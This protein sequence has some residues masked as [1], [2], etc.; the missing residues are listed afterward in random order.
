VVF[1]ILKQI[2]A[3]VLLT[4]VIHYHKVL[5]A[6]ANHANLNVLTY[7]VLVMSVSNCQINGFKC[8]SSYLPS[9]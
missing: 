1:I 5:Q 3:Q 6:E 9:C 7:E 2:F 4:C 8:I